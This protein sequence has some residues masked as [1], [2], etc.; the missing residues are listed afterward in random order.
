MKM[1]ARAKESLIRLFELFAEDEASESSASEAGQRTLPETVAR[2]TV[3]KRQNRGLPCEHRSMGNNIIMVLNGTNEARTFNQW[4]E[5]GR[6]PRR[7]AKA[8]YIFKPYTRKVKEK[9]QDGEEEER[10]A[11][12]GFGP[13]PVFRYEDTEGESV[14]HPDY[15]PVKLPPLTEVAAALGVDVRY[16]PHGGRYLGFYAPGQ[17]AITLM[18]H[19]AR[20]SFHELAHAADDLVSGLKGTKADKEVV[21]ETVAATLGIMYSGKSAPSLVSRAYIEGYVGE[22]QAAKAAAGARQGGEVP[23]AYP[24]LFWGS[25]GRFRESERGGEKMRQEGYA[26]I[27]DLEEYDQVRMELD[28]EGYVLDD[29]GVGYTIDS[30]VAF[31][32]P[33]A[34]CSS[35][36]GHYEA[37]HNPETGSRRGFSMCPQCGEVVEF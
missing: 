6:Y 24:E 3:I 28:T 15:S 1:D 32:T 5:A 21:A 4:K 11:V 34:R 31:K 25:G 8:F 7:G 9:A 19:D 27:Y 37:W 17:R 23:G 35:K 20:V 10:L 16:A 14:D 2:V 33:C 26:T 13:L 22:A 29:S 12:Y 30:W 36:G 18:S